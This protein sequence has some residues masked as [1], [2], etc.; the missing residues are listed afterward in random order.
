MKHFLLILYFSFFSF[1]IN[2]Q[3]DFSFIDYLSKNN[4]RREHFAY[5]NDLSKQTT[6]DTLSYLK[7]KYYLQYY[8]DSLFYINYSNCKK[9]FIND[10]TTFTKAN[11]LFLKPDIT[12]QNRWFNSFENLSLSYVSKNIRYVYLASVSPLNVKSTTLPVPIQESFLNYKK[13]YKKKPI[14]G[15]ALSAA[16]PGLGKLYVGRNRSAVTTFFTHVIYG[17][18]TYES[19]HKLG[20][21]SPSVFFQLVF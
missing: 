19:I 5:L 11:I 18:T 8:N 14:I 16:V 15:G 12:D 2:A 3:T 20:I 4:L 10:T 1:L 21:K 7:A 6:S 13:K 17:V 9:L